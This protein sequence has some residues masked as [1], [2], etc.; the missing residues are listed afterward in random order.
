VPPP[1][2]STTGSPSNTL[3]EMMLPS[4]CSASPLCRCAAIT[5]GSAPSACAKGASYLTI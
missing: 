3:K 2:K 5:C 1:S 4:V